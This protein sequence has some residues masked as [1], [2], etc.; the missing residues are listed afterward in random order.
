MSVADEIVALFIAND[1]GTAENLF[2]NRMPETPSTCGVI[3]DTAG[4]EPQPGFGVVGIQHERPGIQVRFR[5]EKRDSATPYASAQAA[6]RLLIES[7]G[8]ELSGTQYLT[9]TPSQSPYIL[10]RDANNRVIWVFNALLEKEL[11]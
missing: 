3:Y 4:L 7:W 8:T 5:G 6:Y 9:L 11:S 2:T 10:E 1:L